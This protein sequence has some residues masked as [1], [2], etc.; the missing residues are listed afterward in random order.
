MAGEDAGAGNLVGRV[1]PED[2]P[3]VTHEEAKQYRSPDRRSLLDEVIT[4]AAVHHDQYGEEDEEAH[5]LGVVRRHARLVHPYT[6]SSGWTR[7]LEHPLED[8]VGHLHRRCQS[9]DRG[10]LAAAWSDWASLG[11]AVGG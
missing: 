10:E 2:Q 3:A 8:I 4:P 5:E 7:L 6:G 11:V 1:E 9:G